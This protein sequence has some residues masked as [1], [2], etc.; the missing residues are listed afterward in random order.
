MTRQCRWLPNGSALDGLAD[1]LTH[2]TVL[3][4]GLDDAKHCYIGDDEVQKMLRRGDGKL[5][6]H[7]DRELIIRRYLR[8]GSLVHA[9]HANFDEQVVP[10]PVEHIA[11]RDATEEAAEKP[12]RYTASSIMRG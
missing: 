5:E 4:P 2:L 8:F 6:A 3:I 12:R 9:A 11:S 10:S 7:P 1:L